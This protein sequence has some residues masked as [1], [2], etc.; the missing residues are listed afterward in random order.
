MLEC[1]DREFVAIALEIDKY[2]NTVVEELI[3]GELDIEINTASLTE[4][5]TKKFDKLIKN[6]LLEPSSGGSEFGTEIVEE[7]N[8]FGIQQ[9]KQLDK[10]IPSNF[11]DIN[12]KIKLFNPNYGGLLRHIMII[13]DIKRYFEVCWRENWGALDKRYIKL[14]E[15]YNIDITYLRK[16]ISQI[17]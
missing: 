17:Y 14:F 8:L 3:K 12:I 4:Y 16:Y 15:E 9:L 11:E 10:I 1:A 7:L 2:K 13:H 6:K 5:I